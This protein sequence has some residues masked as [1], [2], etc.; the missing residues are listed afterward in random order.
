MS[1]SRS[2]LIEDP[3]DV[4][5]NK[6]EKGDISEAMFDLAARRRGWIVASA[7]GK[8]RDFDSV[9]KRPQLIRPV[10]VQIKLAQQIRYDSGSCFYQ[11]TCKQG[12]TKQSYSSTAFD[13]L[14][15]HL[16][17]V[18]KFVF[19]RREEIGNR[20]CF[21]YLLPEMRKYRTRK[22]AMPNRNPD[23]WELLDEVAQSTK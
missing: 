7:H 1:V 23:N 13:I 11:V 12:A 14:A 9:V 18:D 10:S 15:V 16:F 20:L 3:F 21:M 2:A 8:A 5:L 22:T 19:Y 4:A 6:C 17:D